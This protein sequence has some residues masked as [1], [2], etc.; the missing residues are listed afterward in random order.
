MIRL[1]IAGLLCAAFGL[2]G[3]S[4]MAAAAETNAVGEQR[5]NK[6]GICT[7]C[8]D[9][10]ETKPILAIYQTPHGVIA[11]ERTPSCQSCHGESKAH[12]A[13]DSEGKGRAP[14]D[15]M[16]GSQ[17]HDRGIC[18]ER[19]PVADR[20]LPHVSQGEPSHALAGQPAPSQRRRLRRLPHRA[21]RE[22]PDAGQGAAARRLLQLPQ[23]T[24]R[25][26]QADLGAPAR[27]RQDGLL[28][29]PQSARLG[30]TASCW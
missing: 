8:H 22:G 30:R 10:S 7:K 28:G 25:A 23:G 17:A 5:L 2:V 20:D 3:A 4:T 11:D 15:M 14:P 9:E 6:D 24:A 27:R 29:L 12:L 26:D 16:F 18:A 13:G 21:Q 19:R 1:A